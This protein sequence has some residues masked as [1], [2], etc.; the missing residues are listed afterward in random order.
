[1]GVFETENIDYAG[2]TAMFQT[3]V[4][5]LA[6]LTNDGGN[7]FNALSIRLSELSSTFLFG[8]PISF[9]GNL[10]AGGTVTQAFSI[11]GVFGFELFSFSSSFSHLVSL[12]WVQGLA[13]TSNPYFQFDD[14]QSR[15]YL[16]SPSRPRCRYSARLLPAWAC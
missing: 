8:G 7:E 15:L 3:F 6:S 11:D 16:P 9:T 2:S 1:L 12:S 10:A 13:S 4:N 14:I 5:S